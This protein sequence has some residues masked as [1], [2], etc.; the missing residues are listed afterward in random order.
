MLFLFLL[1]LVAGMVV[2]VQT[3]INTKL[4]RYTHSSFYSSAISFSV[5]A[6]FLFVVNLMMSPGRFTPSFFAGQSLNYT[7]FVGGL[8]GVLFLTGNLLLF[9]K[10]GASLTVII[11][12]AGQIIMGVMI[13]TFGW[14]G[15]KTEPFTLL[16]LLGVILLFIGIIV[17]NYVRNQPKAEQSSAV[18]P[19]LAIGFVFG[20][21]PPIQTAI[22]SQLGQQV[23]SSLFASLISFTMG[24]IALIIITAC[25]NRSFKLSTYEPDVGKIK[26][27]YFIGGVLGV[28]FVTVNIIL[29]PHLG[30]ALTTIVG[31]LGQ[32]LMGVIIDHFG[33]L[34][35]K[36]N[37]INLRK[38]LG[39]ICIFIGIVLLRFF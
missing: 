5:G 10:L 26:P 32:M 34:G 27:V 11:T 21:G 30:A 19:W 25:V 23:H 16:K 6:L 14:L 7:W 31:M 2:P 4:V 12:I 20:F 36:R 15:A 3:S 13:D 1:G 22:N 8:L 33:I 28:V 24:A 39:I 17:M 18:L 38:I 29:M 35:A 9:P 37:R